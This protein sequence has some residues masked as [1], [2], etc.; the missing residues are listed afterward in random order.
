MQGCH[1]EREVRRS[2]QISWKIIVQKSR[3]G[4]FPAKPL[5]NANKA[6]FNRQPLLQSEIAA[7]Q[8]FMI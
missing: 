7:E 6:L 3:L 5:V 2:L 4:V 8:K 1:A